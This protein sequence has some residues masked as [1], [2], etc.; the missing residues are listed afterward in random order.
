M[1]RFGC[2]QIETDVC[3]IL[4][5]LQESVAHLTTNMTRLLSGHRNT[6]VSGFL[7]TVLLFRKSHHGEM[8]G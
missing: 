3:Q 5:D 7:M 6:A 2:T 4:F 8:V 1:L